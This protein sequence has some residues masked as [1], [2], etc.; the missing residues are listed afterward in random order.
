MTIASTTTANAT[1]GIGIVRISGEKSIE[2]ANKVTSLDITKF[3]SHTLHLCKI[4]CDGNIID[5]ALVSVFLAPNSYTGEDVVEINCHGGLVVCKMVLDA[6]Y[7]NGAYPA[8]PGEYTKRAFMNGKMDLSQAEAVADLISAGTDNEVL[9]AANQLDR[10]LSDMIESIRADLISVTSHIL[11]MIDFSEEGVEELDYSDLADILKNADKKIGELIL[12]AKSG[13]IIKDGIKTAIIGTPNVG[14]SSILNTICGEERAIVTNI[15]GTTRDVIET[16]VNILGC[17]LNLFDTAGI[18]ES[19]NCVEQIGVEKSKDAIKNADLV[20]LVIDGS[21]E[22]DERDL[23]VMSL[24]DKE[25]TICLI[26][27]C[28]LPFVADLKNDFLG[29]FKLSA[30]TGEGFDKLYKFIYDTYSVGK[31]KEKVIITNERHRQ[32]LV[33]AKSVIEEILVSVE[34]N[35]PFDIILG[36]TEVLISYLGEIGGETVSDEIIDSIFANFCVGK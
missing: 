2:I 34:N 24:A 17:K 8:P 5:E 4:I 32:S 14:K 26:N 18:R 33:K 21:R 25:K 7:K 19:D 13:R 30:V 31:I 23:E 16:Q 22:V 11:A 35:V 36:D 10:N 27:K 9:V 29:M 12:T 28:D 6:L 20:F 3:K 15:A 1:G